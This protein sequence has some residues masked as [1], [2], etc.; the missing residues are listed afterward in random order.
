MN[1]SAKAPWRTAA[2]ASPGGMVNSVSPYVRLGGAAGIS[3]LVVEFY[4]RVLA[5]ADLAPSPG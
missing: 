5:D 2:E 1:A 3:D 4:E